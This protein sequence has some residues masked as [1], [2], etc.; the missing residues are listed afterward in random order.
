MFST[1]KKRIYSDKQEVF[2]S[3]LFGEAGGDVLVAYKLAGYIG[4]N[5]GNVVETLKDEIIERAK[6]VLA[7]N[8]PRAVLTL[9]AA[10]TEAGAT[11]PG[12][13]L[14]VTAAQQVLDRVGIIKH[15]KLDVNIEAES[16][17][18]I[19]PPKNK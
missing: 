19:L 18:F 2:M 5:P 14:K 4:T 8:S 11:C 17:I 9:S 16:G 13:A 15:D 6:H 12:A 10:M 7:A 3:A 1:E